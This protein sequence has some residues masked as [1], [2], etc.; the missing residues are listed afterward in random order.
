MIAVAANNSVQFIAFVLMC[1]FNNTSA[2]RRK[3]D[4]KPIQIQKKKTPERQNI[5]IIVDCQLLNG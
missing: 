4:T 1:R 5:I 3:Y 2:Q